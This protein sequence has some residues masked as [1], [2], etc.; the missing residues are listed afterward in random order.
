M[1]NHSPRQPQN[2]APAQGP[3]VIVRSTDRP[4]TAFGGTPLLRQWLHVLRLP[5]RLGQVQV[6]WQ[7]R[8]FQ[9]VDYLFALLCGLLVG[10]DRQ[11]ALAQLGHD[12][13]ALLG[14][15]LPHMPSQPAL[16]RFLA[17]GAGGVAGQILQLSRDLGKRMRQTQRTAI[18]DL[19][20]SVI[21]T[22]GEPEGAE[23]GYNPGWRGKTYFA[24]LSFCGHTREILEVVSRV[25][26][27]FG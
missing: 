21:A 6:P 4:V 20:G 3:K 10:C 11:N 9:G 26:C 18:L 2:P 14:L 5:E 15:G 19:D 8:K 16:S 13:G 23:W 24:C 7:G 22:R 12:F 27:K 25:V 17:Q 1:H